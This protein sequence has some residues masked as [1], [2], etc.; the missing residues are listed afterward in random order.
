[1]SA[2]QAEESNVINCM[3]ITDPAACHRGQS[4]HKKRLAGDSL[5][6]ENDARRS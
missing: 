5:Q 6:C 4:A 1:M 3:Q 2:E